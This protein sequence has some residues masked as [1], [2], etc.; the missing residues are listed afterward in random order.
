MDLLELDREASSFGRAD[1]AGG[2]M[3]L[4]AA[5]TA[6]AI[7][8]ARRFVLRQRASKEALPGD[9]LS[10]LR[11]LFSPAW[12]IGTFAWV[13]VQGSMDVSAAR[14]R[15]M[16]LVGRDIDAI[17]ELIGG[18]CVCRSSLSV[19]AHADTGKRSAAVS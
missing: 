5:V 2:C 13:C 6:Q 7:E 4:W 9:G 16:R 18:A 12:G 1:P 17:A 8:D 14:V 3:D 10:A 19:S 11:W 15:F